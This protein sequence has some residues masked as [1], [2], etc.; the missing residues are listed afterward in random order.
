MNGETPTDAPS[1]EGPELFYS[2]LPEFVEQFI[3]YTYR[4]RISATGGGELRWHAKWW[5]S[6]EATM[7]LNGLWRAFEQLRQ[8]A[9]LGLSVFFRDHLDY[10]MGV[11]MSDLGPFQGMESVTVETTDPLPCAPPPTG[12]FEVYPSINSQMKGTN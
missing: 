1:E 2:S 9:A 7:R 5:E 3:C 8:D 12:M 4:R 11:L 6:A 10:H